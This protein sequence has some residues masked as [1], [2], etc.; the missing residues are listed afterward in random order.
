MAF[1][2]KESHDIAFLT[3]SII[4]L[5]RRA[6]NET[7]EVISKKLEERGFTLIDEVLESEDLTFTK[8]AQNA[9]EFSRTYVVGPHCCQ[10]SPLD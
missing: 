3:A 6:I 2:T 4:E 7:L 1:E 5:Q 8:A 10:H 9:Q